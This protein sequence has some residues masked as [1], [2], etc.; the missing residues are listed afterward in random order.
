MKE[1]PNHSP[2]GSSMYVVTE[3]HWKYT[4]SP[5][6]NNLI[7]ELENLRP[8]LIERTDSFSCH[9]TVTHELNV[10]TR[11]SKPIATVIWPYTIYIVA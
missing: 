5:M 2:L 6:H 3:K 11:C 1:S 8:I 10:F 7:Y 9:V 4:L